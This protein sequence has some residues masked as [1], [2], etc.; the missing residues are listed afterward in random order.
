MQ[1]EFELLR[2]KEII[3]ILDGDTELGEYKD[4]KLRMPYLTGQDLCNLSHTFGLP[5]TYSWGKGVQNL[6]RWK[7][8]DNLLEY[9]I[10]EMKVS[11]LLLYMMS[12]DKFQDMLKGLSVSEIEEAYKLIINKTIEKINSV[13]YFGGHELVLLG[14]QYYINKIG[15]K[16]EI[17]APT[18]KIIDQQYIKDLS[19][20]AL[21]DIENGSLDSAVT[22]ARTILEET[23][24][25]VI[26]KKGE[27]PSGSGDILKLYKQIKDLYSMHA[28]QN[29]DKRTNTLLS[30]LEKIVS[31]IAEMRNKNSDSHGV[32]SN[33][34]NISS[35]HARLCVNASVAMADFIVS[36]YQNTIVNR[37]TI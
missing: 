18:I 30:G 10:K 14:N 13:L 36:V 21:K 29:M 22:K 15:T 25:Y 5:Q 4:V 32:G 19:D 27:T 35:Y 37:R 17:S 20:R 34:I 23:F 24:W 33:R 6:S 31:A 16:I 1:N 9:C 11:N 12:K 7:Y 3:E 8:M 28:D 2:N 26:E